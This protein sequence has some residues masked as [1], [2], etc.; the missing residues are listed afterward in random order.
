VPT[1][2]DSNN[3]N[4]GNGLTPATAKTSMSG[5][6]ITNT[7][8]NTR[9]I[10]VASGSVFNLTASITSAAATPAGKITFSKYVSGYGSNAN[11]VIYSSLVGSSHA[12][13]FRCDPNEFKT[14]TTGTNIV[15][16]TPAALASRVWYKKGMGTAWLFGDAG[17]RNANG[18]HWGM[19][20]KIISAPTNG[21]WPSA[22]YH[23]AEIYVT[24]ING[25]TVSGGSEVGTLFW[26]SNTE[27][28]L[29]YYGI[30]LAQTPGSLISIFRPVAGFEYSGIDFGP[31][32]QY[33]IDI[34]YGTTDGLSGPVVIRDFRMD[35]SLGMRIGSGVLNRTN[36][37]GVTGLL[38]EDII[39]KN[40]GNCFIGTWGGG[41]V[42]AAYNSSHVFNNAIIRHN[43]VA[44]V[45][46]RFSLGGIYL[47]N[48]R[49]TDGSKIQVY[50]NTVSGA[51]RDNVWP[52]GYAIYTDFSA[53]DYDI[54]RNYV[55]DSD[56]AFRNNGTTGV[57][58][59]RENVAIAKA[60]ASA[61]SSAFGS[62]DPND[63]DTA[64]N[65]TLSYN[66][67][68]GFNKFAGYQDL[69]PAS[70]FNI[71]HNVSVAKAGASY[72]VDSR[73][74]NYLTLDYNNF[75][76]YATH[77]SDTFNP[78]GDLSYLATHIVSGDPT[79]AL[80]AGGI[81][82][83]PT[84]KEFNYALGLP[85]MA[86]SG[87]AP[88]YGGVAP[89]VAI[90]A[91]TVDAITSVGTSIAISNATSSKTT[92]AVTSTG[93]GTVSI[94][95]T[96]V[97]T[98]DAITS[99]GSSTLSA[100]ASG[101]N[102]VD[103]LVG[104]GDVFLVPFDLFVGANLVDDVISSGTAESLA[105]AEGA[106]TVI[107]FS[108][109]ATSLIVVS[110]VATGENTTSVSSAGTAVCET[111]CSGASTVEDT[112]SDGYVDVESWF[113]GTNTVEVTSYGEVN[114]Y[115]AAVSNAVLDDVFSG[116]EI[117]TSINVVGANTVDD[118]TAYES[119]IDELLR[120]KHTTTRR[121]TPWI[122]ETRTTPMTWK[123]YTGNPVV[124]RNG[125]YQFTS[126]ATVLK[127]GSTYRMVCSTDDPNDYGNCLRMYTSSNG[128]PPWS[129]LANGNGG[130]VVPSQ[131]TGL[132]R[133]CENPKLIK[134][135]S[136]YLLFYVGYDPAVTEPYGGL[137]WG[138]VFLATSTDGVTFT[139][140]GMVLQR[141][142]AP[143]FDQ[144]GITEV[145][146]IEYAGT[147]YMIYTGWHT[148]SPTFNGGN[149]AIY[150]CKATSADAGRTW[151]KGGELNSGSTMGLQHTDI[152]RLP[153][154]DFAIYY[155]VDNTSGGRTG[156][157]EATASSPHGQY[158]QQPGPLWL[159][160]E[161]AFESVGDEGGFPSPIIDNGMK[162]VYYTGVDVAALS[163]KIGLVEFK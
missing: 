25:V 64:A 145:T 105:S 151:T 84:D 12:N 11:P 36:T 160:G 56:L 81:V 9:D 6:A 95:A 29:D 118:I 17:T 51:K 121:H 89:K 149:P 27:D 99:T 133:S 50:E 113:V 150:C 96:G 136:E 48:C 53:D 114:A 111:L 91:N 153:D 82:L 34:G 126:D 71:H 2:F 97:T 77:W 1:Y 15:T 59:V 102:L 85:N 38:I 5:F 18:T 60:G 49:T 55:W 43:V 76:G 106:N 141:S 162:R 41:T 163:F 16:T 130:I 39:A 156:I 46:E 42:P 110:V 129:E 61:S 120:W 88:S 154:G 94:S 100:S 73:D 86:W 8:A 125:A 66:V 142:A 47:L 144:D 116:G 31:S 117:S 40:L 35:R 54:Y 131:N 75:Y 69:V 62:N 132:D 112:V 22:D 161:Q 139:R 13:W 78:T 90:G 140:Q 65:I 3:P 93:S 134:V 122:T 103:D 128:Y 87:A 83:N 115:T 37:V 33:S 143:S 24:K 14:G 147:L 135:G 7:D 159:M 124:S 138:D 26:S 72:A 123:R 21:S 158:T 107:V 52:D 19:L 146:V 79:S 137:V 20:R 127:D 109:S 92:D 45:C 68:I 4:P 10:R 67:S 98:I 44:G 155:G 63:V 152:V 70:S 74:S 57:G 157:F 148:Q 28:P 80:L 32:T 58:I 30:T 101:A 108:D 119:L 23:I 104:D